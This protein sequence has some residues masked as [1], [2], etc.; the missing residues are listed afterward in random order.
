MKARQQKIFRTVKIIP[1]KQYLRFPAPQ[2]KRLFPF[3][4][5]VR[6]QSA[7]KFSAEHDN[8]VGMQRKTRRIISLRIGKC[9]E[10]DI[11]I[12]FRHFICNF[13]HP[14]EIEFRIILHPQPVLFAADSFQTFC[15]LAVAPIVI[16][17]E[18]DKITF[19]PIGIGLPVIIKVPDRVNRFLFQF[20]QNIGDCNSFRFGIAVTRL[21]ELTVLTRSHSRTRLRHDIFFPVQNGQNFLRPG[22]VFRILVPGKHIFRQSVRTAE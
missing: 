11:G 6:F 9:A 8:H 20:L 14:A 4:P 17:V 12:F 5:D 10:V 7:V 13:I 22:I 3:L 19:L 18:I 2:L 16:G 21:P 1:D 15:T